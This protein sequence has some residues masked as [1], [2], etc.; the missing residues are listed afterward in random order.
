M[1]WPLGE[2]LSIG[3]WT[4]CWLSLAVRSSIIQHWRWSSYNKALCCSL[5]NVENHSRSGIV[6]FQVCNSQIE[7]DKDEQDRD[8][9]EMK[10]REIFGSSSISKLRFQ[11]END[12]EYDNVEN[13]WLTTCSTLFRT[14]LWDFLE[15]PWTSSAASS[16][17][18]VSLLIVLVSTATFIISTFEVWCSF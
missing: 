7:G 16:Y 13:I 11:S 9:Q 1:P 12:L 15:K 5:F 10:E 14:V 8:E 17:A 4:S 18:I 2:T 3:A 6:I